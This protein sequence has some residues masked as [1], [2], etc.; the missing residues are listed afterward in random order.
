MVQLDFAAAGGETMI[1]HPHSTNRLRELFQE[2]ALLTETT[3][4]EKID[5]PDFTSDIVTK[6]MDWISIRW[7]DAGISPLEDGIEDIE[8]EKI[9]DIGKLM[10]LALINLVREVDY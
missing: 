5:S 1:V 8:H 10:S 2:T 9:E 3:L 7:E 6:R 4:N